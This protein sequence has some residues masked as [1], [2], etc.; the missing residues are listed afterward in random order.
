MSSFPIP[1]SN[2]LSKSNQMR[3]GSDEFLYLDTSNLV[4]APEKPMAKPTLL[5]TTHP[6]TRQYRRSSL[7]SS[8]S[9]FSN[10]S[11][12]HGGGYRRRAPLPKET[13]NI[14]S[15]LDSLITD[16]QQAR[17]SSSLIRASSGNVMLL[18]QFGNL[19]PPGTSNPNT[20][21]YYNS[22][23]NNVH[24]ISNP[25]I[26]R[27]ACDD[28]I[29]KGTYA[30]GN[31][32]SIGNGVNQA[33]YPGRW[34]RAISKGLDAEK[35]KTMGNE[36]FKK[37]RLVEALALYDRA[38]AVNPEIAT[39]RNN[40]G[41]V[42]ASMNRLLEAVFECREAVRIDPSY[43]RAH[44]CLGALYLRLGEPEKSLE[45]FK[46]SGQEAKN[47]EIA[48]AEELLRYINKFNEAKKQNNWMTVLKEA[49][50]AISSGADS[51][52]QVF[53]FKAEAL[54]KLHRHEEACK[55][56]TKAPNFALDDCTKFYGSIGHAKLL[57]VQ[58]QVEMSDGRFDEAVA[59]SQQAFRLYPSDRDLDALVRRARA[60][61]L[62]RTN[63]NE[64]FKI[65]KYKEACVAYTHGLEHDPLNSILL[66]NRA[67]CRFKLN[68]FE[69]ASDDCTKALIVCP[70]H[71]GARL[72]RADCKAKM[73]CWEAAIRDYEMVMRD[74]PGDEAAAKA[75]FEAQLELRSERG[76]D[77]SHMRFVADVIS[78]TGSD[79]FKQLIFEG[80]SVVD[81]EDHPNLIRQE[82]VSSIPA[83]KIYKN[84]LRLKE[85]LGYNH[86]SLE[87]FI[88]FYSN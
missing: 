10:G 55:T 83:F 75:L 24:N 68:H 2:S 46:L 56:L 12:A 40:K 76:E 54:L 31:G 63:G 23:N 13:I 52:L 79:S 84:G 14:N 35:L 78:I 71:S 8:Y 17:E 50:H 34:R 20:H 19:R 3:V 18:R 15:E 9:S 86:D 30:S 67:S 45:H 51:A 43:Q 48:K 80:M 36:E 58:A 42:L 81:A 87:G 28:S 57:S 70:T 6:D 49:E 33:E 59:S 4:E 69:M 16:R 82:G 32:N 85:I 21:N 65:G 25:S 74:I 61:S 44:H 26:R 1:K 88:K 22:I 60:A 29:P 39:C 5:T 11:M 73:E 72:R 47:D 53:I 77:I 66:C 27:D 41:I 64:L 37:G 7:P 38:I 62:A